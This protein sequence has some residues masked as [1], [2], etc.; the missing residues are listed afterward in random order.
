MAFV[1]LLFYFMFGF[2]GCIM[3][4]FQAY[5]MYFLGG[6][7]PLLGDLLD[8]TTPPPTWTYP[9]G[10]PPPQIFPPPADA[11]VVSPVV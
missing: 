8:R 4:F 10:F 11:P 2:M 9:V 3:T 7:Y 1:L 5:G 6:R